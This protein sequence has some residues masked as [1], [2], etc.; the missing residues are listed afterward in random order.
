MQKT[1]SNPLLLKPNPVP[2][3]VPAQL[4]VK[5]AFLGIQPRKG[6][7]FR[8]CLHSPERPMG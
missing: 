1:E 2:P 8:L 3:M 7:C 4:I 6:P 5:D